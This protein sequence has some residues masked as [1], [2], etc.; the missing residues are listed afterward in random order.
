[1]DDSITLQ[2]TEFQPWRVEADPTP[3]EKILAY[4]HRSF[5]TGQGPSNLFGKP[6][7]GM[8]ADFSVYEDLLHGLVA[9]PN[10]TFDTM[11]SVA[12]GRSCDADP[13]KIPIVIRHDIDG[14]IVTAVRMAEAEAAL[15]IRSSYYVLYASRYYGDFRARH[16]EG[17]DESEKHKS[18]IFRRYEAMA[19]LYLRI[20]ELGHEVGLHFFPYGT[21]RLKGMDGIEAMHEE[22]RWLR[23]LGLKIVGGCGHTSH[24]SHGADM[25]E[26][27]REFSKCAPGDPLNFAKFQLRQ[28][29]TFTH[30]GVTMPRLVASLSDFGFDYIV[31][32]IPGKSYLYWALRLSERARSRASDVT[33]ARW[34]G[35][36]SL[37]GMLEQM[38]EQLARGV[39]RQFIMLMVHPE[40]FGARAAPMLA[41]EGAVR[42]RGV[43]KVL[44]DRFGREVYE[45]RTVHVVEF[46]SE[47]GVKRQNP[48]MANEFGMLDK[49]WADRTEGV[50]DI[51][52]LG[53]AL[54]D[55]PRLSQPCQVPGWMRSL[56]KKELGESLGI[57][58]MALAGSGPEDFRRYYKA[59]TELT[60]PRLV[61][62]FIDSFFV[63]AAGG[64]PDAL[65]SWCLRFAYDSKVN[66]APVLFVVGDHGA[67]LLSAPDLAAVR[68]SDLIGSDIMTD[69]RPLDSQSSLAIARGL[70]MEIKR[71]WPNLM[72]A[73]TLKVAEDSM[74]LPK[75]QTPSLLQGRTAQQL[76][77]DVLR[78]FDAFL[79]AIDCREMPALGEEVE[80]VKA[81]TKDAYYA[82]TLGHV[83]F[84]PDLASSSGLDFACGRG[85]KTALLR[86]FGAGRVSGCDV[87]PTLIEAA[88]YW[89]A[90]TGSDIE[91]RV[92]P[93]D[94]IPFETGAFDWVTVMG[95]YA[96]LN[97]DATMPLFREMSRVLKPGGLL[98]FNDSA[99]PHC[100][101]GRNAIITHRTETE[102]GPGTVE[103]PQGKLFQAR[104]QTIRTMAPSLSDA[105]ARNLALNTSYMWKPQIE[106]AL[107][108]YASEGVM[109][110]QR[111]DPDDVVRTPVWPEHGNAVRR[112][113]DPFQIR[114]ELSEAGFKVYFKRPGIGDLIPEN[115]LGNYFRSAP[116]VFIVAQKLG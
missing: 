60:K 23:S 5:F 12:A 21:Y 32:F 102:I 46:V 69:E 107:A 70:L 77:E 72:A 85:L 110:N 6:D 45:P 79:A 42:S 37:P 7:K 78:R 75:I 18:E 62:A 103:A 111:F 86:L 67:A 109:P 13:G 39:D 97:P 41:E 8:A 48:V 89:V 63:A 74:S 11:A 65:K 88:N 26:I 50:A 1:M 14:D 38:Q 29:R 44:D 82:T 22:L 112:A 56:T 104:L 19:P 93:L 108:K 3:A 83:A 31:E 80:R 76:R 66:G 96:N 10:V 59:V 81:Q 9:L 100:D 98:L 116:G 54:L 24:L 2:L 61:V 114:D 115:E 99:N 71:R 91:F 68:L 73:R 28:D 4:S 55:A 17:H 52:L 87:V 105:E 35:D 51:L 15:G 113:T 27:F 106:A 57:T 43:R 30:G 84:I 34:Q 16:Q 58:K 25:A 90:Q 53:G 20:Q 49:C 64:D 36:T 95:L 94:S 33:D 40:H 47:R 101:K 92:N